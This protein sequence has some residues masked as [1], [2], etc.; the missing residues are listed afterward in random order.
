MTGPPAAARHSEPETQLL[1]QIQVAGSM[2]EQVM[3]RRLEV[4]GTDLAAMGHVSA[5]EPPI[6]PRELSQRLGLSPAA[7]TEVVDRLE[8][9]GHLVRQRD[10][11]DRRRVQLRPSPTAVGRVL[12]EIA[13][14]TR[15]LD[16][17]ADSF[18]DAERAVIGRY[19]TGVLVAYEHFGRD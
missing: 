10:T 2:A 9:A 8:S 12:T 17:L 5:A 16:R 18:D 4:N 13:P 11:R 3:A 14:L 7:V 15:E 6:G 19:L 1:R